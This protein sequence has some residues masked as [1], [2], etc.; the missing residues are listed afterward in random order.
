MTEPQPFEAPRISIS[1]LDEALARARAEQWREISLIGP[2]VSRFYGQRLIDQ[3]R[4]I[5]HIFMLEE[6][7]A[8]IV[9]KA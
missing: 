4:P 1:E 5:E 6:P 3:G 9:A 2:N 8:E 7:S